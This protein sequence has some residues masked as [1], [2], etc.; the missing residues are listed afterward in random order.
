MAV[1]AHQ[2][3]GA[4]AKPAVAYGLAREALH[5]DI[6][7]VAFDAQLQALTGVSG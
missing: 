4:P 7:L 5:Q 2:R 3:D 6:D 1:A